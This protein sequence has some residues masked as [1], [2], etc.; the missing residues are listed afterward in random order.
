M[1]TQIQIG[2]GGQGDSVAAQK[3]EATK[4]FKKIKKLK[5][6]LITASTAAVLG[7]LLFE[8]VKPPPLRFLWIICGSSRSMFI[9]LNFIIL[10]L[11]INSGMLTAQNQSFD[12][13]A[14]YFKKSAEN[15]AKYELFT[16]YTG[17]RGDGAAR[18]YERSRSE[19]IKAASVRKF[20]RSDSAISRTCQDRLQSPSTGIVSD[21]ELNKRVEDF[22][23][24]F[25]RQ[26]RL[27]REQSLSS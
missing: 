4:K 9:L 27:Q 17:Q 24:N 14:E 6:I 12:I 10:V 19:K 20:K 23:A 11:N 22:I 2:G 8:T 7:F 25:N 13:Y 5:M 15:R 1:A 21:E 18:K 26:L 3:S 16:D